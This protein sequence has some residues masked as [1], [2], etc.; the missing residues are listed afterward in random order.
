MKSKSYRYLILNK[1]IIR[2]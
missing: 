2:F 1:W